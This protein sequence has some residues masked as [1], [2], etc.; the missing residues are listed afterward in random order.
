MNPITLKPEHAA[1]VRKLMNNDKALEAFVQ[2]VVNQGQRRAQENI[3]ASRK[4]WTET[5]AKDPDYNLNL[6]TV[7]YEPSADGSQLVPTLQRFKR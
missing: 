7:Q 2:E 5:L 6:E 1:Q 4:F 3:E